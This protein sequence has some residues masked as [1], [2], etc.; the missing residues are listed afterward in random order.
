MSRTVPTALKIYVGVIAAVGAVVVGTSVVALL[1]TPRFPE[2][3]A[4]T[5]L[6][7]IAS[8]FPLRVPGT[9]AWFSIADTFYITSALLFGPAPATVTMAIDSIIMSKGPNRVLRR[10]LFNGSAPAIA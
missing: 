5:L 3:G 1:G 6:A 9:L 8:R 7:L 2:W 4:L 10:L